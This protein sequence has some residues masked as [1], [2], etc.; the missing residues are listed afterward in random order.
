MLRNRATFFFSSLFKS[1]SRNV[2]VATILFMF[3]FALVQMLVAYLVHVEP[4]F[5]LSQKSEWK[6]ESI[7]ELV[8]PPLFNKPNSKAMQKSARARY[9]ALFPVSGVFSTRSP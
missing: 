9:Y 6:N 1:S 3:A 7:R 4:W 5:I 2:L 8:S